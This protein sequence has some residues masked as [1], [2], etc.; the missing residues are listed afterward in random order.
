MYSAED[1]AHLWNTRVTGTGY[2]GDFHL[3]CSYSVF[4]VAVFVMPEYQ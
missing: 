1:V 4:L 3:G 2:G